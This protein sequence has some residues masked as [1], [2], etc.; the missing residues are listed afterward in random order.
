[1]NT[2]QRYVDQ[3]H[4]L[5]PVGETIPLILFDRAGAC[6]ANVVVSDDMSMREWAAAQWLAEVLS[7]ITETEM[8]VKRDSEVESETKI[9]VGDVD[10]LPLKSADLADEEISIEVRGK[11]CHVQGGL[12][13]GLFHAVAAFLEEDLACRW[14]AAG[15]ADIPALRQDRIEIVNRR[16]APQLKLRDPYYY[17]SFDADWS[18]KNRTNAPDARVPQEFGGHIHYPG[19]EGHL[20]HEESLFVHTYH[21][22]LPPKVWFETHPEYYEMNDQGERIPRQLCETH[23]DVHRVVS[24]AVRRYL[25]KY[26]KAQLLSVSKIDGGGTCQCERCSTLNRAEGSDA[27]SLLT[28]VNAVA[29][30]IRKDYPEVTITTLAYLETIDLPKTLRP[31]INVGIRFCN[32]KVAWP[33]PF[34]RARDSEEMRKIVEDWSSVCQKLYVWDYN[35]NF[36]HYAAPMPNLDIIADNIRFWCEHKAEGIMT[37]GAYQCHGSE[38]DVMKSWIIAKLLWNPN[39]NHEALQADFIGGYYRQAAPAVEKYVKMLWQRVQNDEAIMSGKVGCRYPMDSTFLQGDFLEKSAE[40]FDQAFESAQGDEV[41]VKRLERDELCLWYVALEQGR[42]LG[43]FPYEMLIDRFEER[44]LEVGFQFVGET[45]ETSL[46]WK[47]QVWRD[48]EDPSMVS[49][50]PKGGVFEGPLRVKVSTPMG[51]VK[52]TYRT[53][54]KNPEVNDPEV[55]E[56]GIDITESC[57]LKI[58]MFMVGSCV[59][60]CI[61][62]V[63]YELATCAEV[64]A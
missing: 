30:D 49:V 14:Y 42:G 6:I 8:S 35:A 18:L 53:D 20:W 39:L 27:A 50:E 16:Y 3:P 61:A 44:A 12:G 41:L 32:D 58:G 5:K 45:P 52:L 43:P 54:G 62:S 25:Q 46:A 9:V 7:L 36:S 38:F 63:D 13:R 1:M 64:Q 4:A 23:P 2:N 55:T 34:G 31:E 37:Q 19:V 26:P 60:D 40:L 47:C 21:Q 24:Q 28:L 48:P 33:K 29:K 10:H 59:G 51:A 57:T 17:C 56:E 15:A 11:V 22:L